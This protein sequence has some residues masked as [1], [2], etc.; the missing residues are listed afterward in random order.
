MSLNP[1]SFAAQ[2]NEQFLR[3][4]LTSHPLAD[5]RLAKQAERMVRGE[6]LEGSPLVKGPYL[7][8]SKPFLIGAKVAE[9]VSEGALHPAMQG[10][11]GFPALFQHQLEVLRATKDGRHALVA[12]GTG[13]GKTEAF[14]APILDHC[15]RLRD[16]DAPEGIVAILVYPMNALAQDQKLRLRRMLRGTGISFGMYVGSTPSTPEKVMEPRDQIPP[17]ER[18]SEKEMRER[19]PR[20]L[21]TNYRQL[22]ILLTRGTDQSLWENPPLRYLVFDEAHT[23]SGAVGAEVSC[24]IRRLRTFCGK[25]ADDVLCIGTSATI[26]DPES[27]EEAGREFAHRFFGVPHERVALIGERYAAYEWASELMDEPATPRGGEALLGRTLTALQGGGDLSAIEAVARELLGVP[28]RLSA[29]WREDLFGW[30]QRSRLVRTLAEVL[31]K[32]AHLELAV[33]Q[34]AEILGRRVTD[35][36]GA[37]AE[38]LAVLALGAAAQR[39]GGSLLRPKVHHF[40][41]GL[42]GVV[43]LMPDD[44]ATPQL[45]MTREAALEEHHDRLPPAVWNLFSCETCGQ[46][47]FESWVESIDAGLAEGSNAIYLPA[48]EESGV[49]VLWT[50]R[51]DIEERA[52]DDEVSHR[53]DRKREE[54]FLCRFCGVLHEHG[55]DDCANPKCGRVGS[56]FPIHQIPLNEG[57]LTSC[58][59]CVSGGGRWR[60][61]IRR[62][63]AATTADNHILA[64]DMIQAAARPESQKLLIFTD[65]RQDA[66]FQAGWMSDRARRYRMR[67]LMLQFL[68]EAGRPISVGDV[69]E[70]FLKLF[71]TERALAQALCPEVYERDSDEAFS[72]RLQEELKSYLRIQVLLEW[73]P[74]LRNRTGLEVLGLVRAVY[75]GLP[76]ADDP[77]LDLWAKKAGC[78]AA[79]LLNGIQAWLDT[80]RRTRTLWD[81]PMPVFSKRYFGT[82]D[83]IVARGYFASTEAPPRGLVLI[84]GE[85]PKGAQIVALWARRGRTNTM[86]QARGWG[87]PDAALEDF[88]RELWSKL[89]AEWRHDGRPLLCEAPLVGEK[90]GRLPGTV[91]ARQLDSRLVGLELADGRWTCSVCHRVHTRPTPRMACTRHHCRGLLESSP[92]PKDHYDLANLEGEFTMLMPRE[93]S[94]Q[95][96]NEER[97]LI[98]E[99]FRKVD[100][101]VNCLV[102]TPTLELGVDIGGLDMV[103]LRNVPPTPANY[104]QRVGRAG[105]QERMAVLYTYCRT[106]HHDRYFFE[107]PMRLLAGR[108]TPPRFNL[109]NPVMVRKHVHAAVLSECLRAMR[110][111][112]AWGLGDGSREQLRAQWQQW[113]PPFMRNWL[114]DD[115]D[116]YRNDV[117]DLSGFGKLIAAHRERLHP[118]LSLTFRPAWPEEDRIEVEDSV[119]AEYLDEMPK[120]LE[121]VAARLFRRFQ[122][123]RQRLGEL[124]REKE[125]GKMDRE[126]EYQLRRCEAFIKRMLTTEQRGNYLLSLLSTE[127]FLPGYNEMESGVTAFAARHRQAGQF[128]EEF[129]LGR[130]ASMAVRE[131]VPGNKLYANRGQFRLE[132]YQ[133]PA[134]AD[135]L[136]PV[137]CIVDTDPEHPLVRERGTAQAGYAS[138]TVADLLVLPISD[139]QL[140]YSSRIHDQELDRF[141]LP[142]TVLGYMRNLHRGGENLSLGDLQVQHLRG[143]AVK[144]VNVGPSEKFREGEIGYRVCGACGAVRS[145]FES[146]ETMRKFEEFHRVHWPKIAMPIGLGADVEVDGWRIRSTRWHDL[147]PLA[148]FAEAIRR[149]ASRILEMNEEDLQL[150]PLPVPEAMEI[151]LYDPMPGGS[152][153]LDQLRKRWEEVREAAIALC[154]ECPGACEKSCYECL[155]GYRNSFLHERLDRHLAVELLESAESFSLLNAIAPARGGSGSN[156]SSNPIEKRLREWLTGAGLP[157]PHEQQKVEL[158]PPVEYGTDRI[159]STTPD[160]VY[161]KQEHG[162][163][164]AIYADG[165]H[166][167]RPETRIRDRVIREELQDQGWIVVSIRAAEITD[168]PFMRRQITR[169]EARLRSKEDDR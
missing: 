36:A 92:V 150:L 100:G 115:E 8:L 91:G 48:D 124:F 155:R 110:S 143:Q 89:T 123:A 102:A 85:E 40:A 66:A 117:V 2:V 131:F 132:R 38:I 97:Y 33:D 167:E 68:R 99:Q 161:Y 69:V 93:H 108:V 151:F 84:K 13:S 82:S 168:E 60:E 47:Y 154:E 41:E 144:L 166:H 39:A 122:W 101:E 165:P 79:E 44:G 62:F 4:Q 128:L 71:A 77:W 148:S 157:L 6:Q 111:S 127:G 142:V 53:L 58:P 31:E 19:P 67:H 112:D 26:A 162:A 107:D 64:Q 74:G 23:Y 43:G 134:E 14:L 28:L 12:T 138:D 146:V 1:I 121:E 114:L 86:H 98:E 78:S 50:D 57:R 90:G 9:L 163:N 109:R 49:R 21:I 158:D 160:F 153:L 159:R 95:V 70:A 136:E 152:G 145:P 16:E 63:R 29:N 11:L 45:F 126:R 164:I 37:R 22:E 169:I 76:G 83:P 140:G 147:S 24:L 130:A 51:F 116:R 54:L 137:E 105:R 61:A 35:R 55:G 135:A 103:L 156:P 118:A 120:R 56:L 7:S 149:G 125:A 65:N 106:A 129:P 18:P 3:Y 32:P 81:E 88:S 34:V 27:G 141:R 25:T 119:L 5:E 42:Q 75:A 96:P 139:C 104:W 94:A 73:T 80:V 46:H 87:I 15:L 52:D 20:L 113:F 10:I 17:E 30:M 133:F 72:P 59:V